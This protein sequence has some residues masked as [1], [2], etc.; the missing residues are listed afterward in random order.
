MY[1]KEHPEEKEGK[2]R[3]YIRP[4]GA[5][6][7]EVQFLSTCVRCNKCIEACPHDVIRSLTAVA[8]IAEGTPYLLPEKDPCRW[9]AD[10][11]CI[12][13][14]E[15]GALGFAPDG[16]VPPIA[17]AKFTS[18]KCLNEQGVLCDTCAQRCPTSVKAIRMIGRKVSFDLEKCTG[19]GLCAYHCEAEPAAF[20]ISLTTLTS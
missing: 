8:G 16:T 15:S 1:E 9:C 5:M 6:P 13:A 12:Q 2:P 14:C 17:K 18:D 10:M 3:R 11:P 7:D 4:P 20:S 19:C